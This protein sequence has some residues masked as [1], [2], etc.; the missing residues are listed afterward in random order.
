MFGK[1]LLICH[2]RFWCKLDFLLGKGIWGPLW[3]SGKVR[4]NKQTIIE[5]LGSL[6]GPDKLK[7]GNSRAT[8][9]TLF[10]S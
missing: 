1:L 9:I 3:F 6:P 7:K 8:F 10:S 2:H 5:I 4:E